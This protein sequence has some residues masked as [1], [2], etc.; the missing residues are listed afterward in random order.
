MVTKAPRGEKPFFDKSG[1]FFVSAVSAERKRE[2]NNRCNRPVDMLGSQ[3][4]LHISMDKPFTGY[5]PQ[6]RPP[7]VPPVVPGVWP[8]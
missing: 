3:D 5:D 2:R 4:V 7:N 8:V 1:I 6:L